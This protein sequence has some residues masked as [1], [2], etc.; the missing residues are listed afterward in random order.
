MLAA[1]VE[2]PCMDMKRGLKNVSKLTFIPIIT[3]FMAFTDADAQVL[4][5]K[6]KSNITISLFTTKA[7]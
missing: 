6:Q 5:Q 2:R 4:N 7:I 3:L 1:A